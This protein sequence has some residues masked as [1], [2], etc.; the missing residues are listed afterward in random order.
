MIFLLHLGER[1]FHLAIYTD[2]FQ[3]H[4]QEI[5]DLS[6]SP[7]FYPVYIWIAFSRKEPTV[8]SV[9]KIGRSFFFTLNNNKYK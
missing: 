5:E 7:E 2:I 3:A 6:V 4:H 8:V 9:F 1:H